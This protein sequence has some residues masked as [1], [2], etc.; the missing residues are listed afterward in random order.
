MAEIL[1]TFV[2]KKQALTSVIKP[3]YSAMPSE[4]KHLYI[5]GG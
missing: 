1:Q 3:A 5:S 4:E 2:L